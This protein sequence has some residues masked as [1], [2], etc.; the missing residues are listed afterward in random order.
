MSTDTRLVEFVRALR[1]HGITAGPSETIDAGRVLEVLGLADRE[2]M[3]AGLAAALLRRGGQRTVFDQVF[4]LYFP[5]GIGAPDAQAE[6][7]AEYREQLAEALASGDAG[8][9]TEAARSGVE[10]FGAV[11]SDGGFSAHRTLE[12]IQPQTL[13]AQV[14]EA[15]ASGGFA[16]RLARDT[17]RRRVAEFRERVRTE[18]RRRIAESRGRERIHRHAVTPS[19]ESAELLALNAER[20]A[21]L[22]RTIGPL[23]RKLATRLAARRTHA[24]RGEIDLRRTLRRSLSTGGVP[25]RPAYRKPRP[26]RPEIVLLCDMSGSVANFA[27]FTLLLVQAMRDQFSRVRIFAFVDKTWEVTELFEAT[28]PD[29]ARIAERVRARVA[30]VASLA[31]SDYGRALGTF[32]DWYGDAISPKTSVLVLGDARTNYGSPNVADYG[33]IVATAR[34]VHWLNPEAESRWDTGDSAAGAY[35]A[36]APMHECSTIAA[37]TELVGRILPV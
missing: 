11:D 23:G 36:L 7:L 2:R 8:E 5:L 4:D 22:R 29:P 25:M 3:R 31:H 13:V 24:R 27:T 15:V 32:L 16:E 19:A 33:A 30:P 37:L 17:A 28:D 26:S 35:R 20:L 34:A 10:L 6:S 14:A 1:E 12:A 21:A 9:L 18:A